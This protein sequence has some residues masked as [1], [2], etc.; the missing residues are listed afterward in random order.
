MA[1]VVIVITPSFAEVPFLFTNFTKLAM[2]YIQLMDMLQHKKGWYPE[3]MP[4]FQLKNW[5]ADL[6][7]V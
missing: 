7:D 3:I 6:S 2:A 1:A 4:S 5:D